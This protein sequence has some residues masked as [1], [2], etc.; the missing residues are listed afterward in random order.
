MFIYLPVDA[1]P[2]NE[3][4]LEIFIYSI[5]SPIF[6]SRCFVDFMY[7]VWGNLIDVSLISKADQA[8]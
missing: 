1:P 3:P 5:R 2:P 7:L 4:S 8:L 6:E